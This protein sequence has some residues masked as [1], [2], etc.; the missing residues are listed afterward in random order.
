[1]PA[2]AR[3]LLH[4][5]HAGAARG[6]AMHCLSILERNDG[7]QGAGLAPGCPT[8]ECRFHVTHAAS[9]RHVPAELHSTTKLRMAHGTAL[10]RTVMICLMI[11]HGMM[12]RVYVM[13]RPP[14]CMQT[15]EQGRWKLSADD[16]SSEWRD[17]EPFFQV[18]TPCFA[19]GNL[20]PC[21]PTGAHA[22]RASRPPLA[23][24]S[25]GCVWTRR[26][27]CAA[28]S[29]VL[30]CCCVHL[31]PVGVSAIDAFALRKRLSCSP[32]FLT[33]PRHAFAVYV[34]E[35]FFKRLK[36][37][38]CYTNCRSMMTMKRWRTI[39]SVP[40]PAAPASHSATGALGRTALCPPAGRTR[41]Q[42]ARHLPRC[43]SHTTQNVR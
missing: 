22:H 5:P 25:S 42:R 10:M 23:W 12:W 37:V 27:T 32:S 35:V 15:V 21:L 13:M 14:H 20:Q 6:L 16:G 3:P 31:L 1:V 28:A 33:R 39:T 4:G 17:Y 30:S 26:R 36:S 19:L 38:R 34:L 40:P 18:H 7:G 41:G 29:T 8:S 2:E 9:G 24:G 43:K 11:C